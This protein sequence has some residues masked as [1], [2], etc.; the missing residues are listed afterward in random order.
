MCLQYVLQLRRRWRSVN[1]LSILS[2]VY[3]T[4]YIHFGF[5]VAALVNELVPVPL[6]LLHEVDRERLSQESLRPPTQLVLLLYVPLQ[7][8]EAGR[9]IVPHGV[10]IDRELRA[11]L[12]FK[13]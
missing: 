1:L 6:P 2:I 8:L 12:G 3:G 11:L 13:V 7:L 5:L 10:R 9:A 4:P